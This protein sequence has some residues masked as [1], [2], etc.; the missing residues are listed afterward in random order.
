MQDFRHTNTQHNTRSTIGHDEGLRQYFLKIYALMSGALVMTAL[1]AFSVLSIPALT[2]L[3]YHI[4]PN[5]Q[6]L[7]MTS[8][9]W[10]ISFAPLGIA[11]LFS[12]GMHKIEAQTAQILFWVYAVLMGM[13]LSSLGLMYT[14]ASLVKT[15][16]VCASTFGAMSLYGYTTKKDLTSMGSFLY[17]G[18]IGLIIASVVNLFMQ[19][20]AIEFALS[21]IGVIIFTRLIAYD[22]Q[23]LKSLYFSGAGSDRKIGI[24][25]AFT[26]Y[27]DF[28]NLFIYLLRFL[29]Q[30]K[31]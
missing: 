2:A 14:G 25:A 8:I 23:K 3:M 20:A 11:L 6:I 27:L 22:T 29:G 28:I 19:S 12:F 1:S 4:T 21:F 31:N 10:I 9:G 5:G 13:S 17:M 7:G 15:F 26:L 24:I 18:L 16:F 30:R